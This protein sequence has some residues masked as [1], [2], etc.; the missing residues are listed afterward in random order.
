NRHASTSLPLLPQLVQSFHVPGCLAALIVAA[1][2]FQDVDR[3]F[4]IALNSLWRRREIQAPDFGDL[5]GAH[6]AR[7]LLR[8]ARKAPTGRVL[9]TSSV[10]SQAR[11]ATTT[12]HRSIPSSMV[13]CASELMIRRAPRARASRAWISSRSRRCGCALISSATPAAA[14]AS[15]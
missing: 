11:R 3:A 9:S 6:A 7:F 2:R 13:L 14:A 15:K 10:G 1:E 4:E 8:D 5:V 12:P